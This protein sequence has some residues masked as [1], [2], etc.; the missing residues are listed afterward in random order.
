MV[1]RDKI[2]GNNLKERKREG[3]LFYNNN[4]F[5]IIIVFLTLIFFFSLFFQIYYYPS[6][7]LT[8]LYFLNHEELPFSIEKNRDYNF[9]FTLYNRE[10]SNIDYVVRII[11]RIDDKKPQIINEDRFTLKNHQYKEITESFNIHANFEYASIKVELEYFNKTQEIHF[12]VEGV[13]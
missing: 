1:T 6:L 11:E 12:F 3:K 9:S 2:Y 5:W 4:F 7:G 8:E 13:R 10:G